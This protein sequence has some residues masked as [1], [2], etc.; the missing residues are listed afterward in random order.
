MSHIDDIV[1][2]KIISTEITNTIEILVTIDG[3]EWIGKLYKNETTVLQ[4]VEDS[5]KLCGHLIS[6]DCDKHYY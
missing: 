6:C 5:T 4:P 2:C 3:I 1:E